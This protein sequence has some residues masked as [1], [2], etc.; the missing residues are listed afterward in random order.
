MIPTMKA[1]PS[2][3]FLPLI[4]LLVP[5][6][7]LTQGVPET[8][9]ATQAERLFKERFET[10]LVTGCKQSPPGDVSSVDV[11]CS[12][13]AKSF[14]DR[15][16]ATTLKLLSDASKKYPIARQTIRA[17]LQPEISACARR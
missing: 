10:N 16:S 11:F 3:L 6:P 5:L 1:L 8:Q 9:S 15:Y 17:M 12:C 7:G 2:R 14:V 13:Y 4:L